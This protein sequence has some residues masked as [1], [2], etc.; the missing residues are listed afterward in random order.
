MIA[1]KPS[2][3][4]D[5]TLISSTIAEPDLS[6]GESEW[7]DPGVL[8]LF[9]AYTGDHYASDLANDGN[10]YCVGDTGTVL[11]INIAAQ[12]V[13][14]LGSYTGIYNTAKSGGDGN[15]YCVGD[16]GTVLKINIA[17]QTVST[18]GSYTG[19]YRASDLANDGNIYCVGDT[20]TVLKINIAAQTV[21]TFGAFYG[22]YDA[23]DLANDGNIYCVGDAGTVL[24]INIAAQTVSNFGAF[25][26]QYRSA[27]LG[28]DGNIY[29]VGKTNPILKID[30]AIQ[31]V[32]TFGSYNG[33][34][35]AS[36]LAND[37]NIYCVGDTGTVLKIR[38][39]YL[40]GETAIRTSTHKKYEAVTN[41][42]DDPAVGAA[43]DIPT[44]IKVSATNKYA[45]FDV[46]NST[47]SISDLTQVVEIEPGEVIGG[48]A[49]FNVTGASSVNITMT[50]PV[51]G[52]VYSRDLDMFDNAGVVSWGTYFFSP[53]LQKTGF[54]VADLPPYKSAT[55]KITF[56]GSG[57]IGVGSVAIGYVYKIGQTDYN[58]TSVK[59]LNFDVWNEDSFGNLNIVKRPSAKLVNFGVTFNESNL[60]YVAAALENL[61]G[62][63]AVYVGGD[64]N[65][66]D[67]TAVYGIKRESEINIEPVICTVPITIRG[68]V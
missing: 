43:K 16:T 64:T 1:I 61:R 26:N 42:R 60:N 23:S 65:E 53:I 18:F 30:I 2:L 17:A 10:I 12:T 59:E 33:L 37:G 29:C 56:T 3:I 19:I 36:D 39:S 41:N 28:L 63:P 47:Q 40:V 58:G 31:A 14:T 9:G 49:V 15:I 5:T 38:R 44:W 50:D 57:E 24:K 22:F 7:I 11:K 48:A 51:Y 8:D 32:S 52:V 66:N 45:A 68:F 25:S 46:V 21:S 62:I 35:Y 6:M 67:Y 27:K 4:N 55:T 20:G 13:S 34:L 54:V